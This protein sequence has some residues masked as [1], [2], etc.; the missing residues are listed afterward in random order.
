MLCRAGIAYSCEHICD[1]VGDLHLLT[2]PFCRS[3]FP[4]WEAPPD[5][6][7]SKSVVSLCFGSAFGFPFSRCVKFYPSALAL[8]VSGYFFSLGGISPACFSLSGFPQ[9]FHTLQAPRFTSANPLAKILPACFLD[10]GDLSLVSK[11]SKT[12]SAN[13]VLTEV[14]MGSS[15]KLASVVSSCG[16]LCRTLLLLNHCCFSHLYFPFITWRRERP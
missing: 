16:K 9:C 8:A 7:S 1:S 10:A 12:D 2:N 13:S 3:P 5:S 14:S 6:Q 4:F 15:A 11:L